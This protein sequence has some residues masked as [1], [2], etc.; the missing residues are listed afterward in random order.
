M[1]LDEARREIDK[2]DAQLL[3]LFL[4]RMELAGEIAAYKQK[5]CLPVRDEVREQEILERVAAEA[6]ESAGSAKA[7]FSTLFAL[8]RERQSTLSEI[9]PQEKIYGLVGRKL[10]HS[11]SVPIHALLGNSSYRLI[12]LE[13]EDLP[14]FLRRP[15]IGGLSVTIPY[16]RTVLPLCDELEEGVRL[17][18]SANTLIRD[19]DGR[20][21]AYNTDAGGFSYLA[22]AAGISFAG[23]KVVILGSGGASLTAQAVARRESARSVA[24]ISRKGTENYQN[25]SRHAD[26]EILVNA[27]PVGMYPE[28]GE[29]PVDLRDFPA[30][31][32]V[33]DLIYNPRRTALLMQAEALGI[34]CSGGLPML[35][36]QAA[37]A[38]ALFFGRPVCAGSA[39]R[40]VSVLHRE[41]TNLVLIG[42][43][44]CGKTTVGNL[45]AA[46][47]G[48]KIV[49]TDEE[50]A[51]RAGKSIPEIFMQE[52]E[53]AFRR[54]ER[55]ELARRGRES[56]LILITG[57]GAVLDERNYAS[58][59]QNG[60]IYHLERGIPLLAR[61]G[62]PLSEHADL[63][64]MYRIRL[65]L[66]RRF[67]DAAA[68]NNGTA[69]DTAHAI[70]RDF[71]EHSGD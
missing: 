50:I 24:V 16:K 5:H 10:G 54:L 35:A 40:T 8:S 28:T 39:E 67:Q 4:R 7:L 66:Y 19:A 56:S 60:R 36:Q 2:I 49:D 37:E 45:L 11:W 47:T 58:L 18:G 53:G 14:A 29:S 22:R 25:I 69:E 20:L 27:T 9:N 26:A 15:D 38:E 46:Q 1:E 33:L 52:G 43:P 21:R 23:K 61:R 41:K 51:R 55:E 64:A 17:I 63:A 42:M 65:P 62:R 3:R 48:R 13:P 44:G 59:R 32:G 57:G 31:G 68:D 70:W 6:G 12:E 30:C 71:L 34:P